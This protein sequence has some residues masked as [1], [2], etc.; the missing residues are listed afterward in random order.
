MDSL[1]IKN[2]EMVSLYTLPPFEYPERKPVVGDTVLYQLVVGK[3]NKLQTTDAY[4]KGSQT[5]T[6]KIMKPKQQNNK[7]QLSTRDSFKKPKHKYRSTI[8]ERNDSSSVI[9]QVKVGAIGILILATIIVIWIT[10]YNSYKSIVVSPPSARSKTL[11]FIHDFG[12][13]NNFKCDGRIYCTQM[14]SRAE[15]RFL[16]NI[17]MV[18]K[19]RSTPVNH[20]K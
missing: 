13:P 5:A 8:I 10:C 20:V 2:I 7:E 12:N 6:K 19:C 14:N 9:E 11:R 15:A 3:E 18:Q 16:I 17:A 1:N 4:I